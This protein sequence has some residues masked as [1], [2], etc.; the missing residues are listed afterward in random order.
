MAEVA[1]PLMA[2]SGLYIISKNTKNKKKENFKNYTTLKP[3]NLLNDNDPF[4]KPPQNIDSKDTE[5]S[6]YSLN[7]NVINKSDFKHNNMVPFYSGRTNGVM[8]SPDMAEAKLDQMQGSGS[9]IKQKKEQAP[10]FKPQ[11]D[12]NLANGAPNVNDFIQTRINPSMKMANV[13]PWE[14]ER[15]APG[16][17]KGYNGE[18]GIGFNTGMESRE[19]WQPKTVD[20]LRSTTNPKNTYSLCGHQ[21][22]ANAAI[23]EIGNTQTQGRIEKQTPDTYYESGPNR[24]FTT[25]GL[26]K[27]STSRGI[28]LL[29]DTNRQETTEEY[30]GTGGNG[31]HEATYVKSAVALP[32]KPELKT[33]PLSNPIAVGKYSS[34]ENDYCVKSYSNLPNNRSTTK[35]EQQYG[36]AQGIMRAI[37]A[38][39]LD[40][41]RPTRKEN[42]I[43][44]IRKQGNAS[45]SVN[46]GPIYNPNDKTKTTIRQITEDSIGS[47]YQTIGN[48]QQADAYTVSKHQPIS[49]QRDTT[50]S[51]YLGTAGNTLYTANQTYDAG[52]RQRLNENIEHTHVDYKGNAMPGAIAASKTYDA[53]YN[54]RNNENKKHVNYSGNAA[55][56]THGASQTYYSAYNQRNN[57]KKTQ[58]SRNN[59]GG[60][61]IFNQNENISISR[62]DNDRI[63]RRTSVPNVNGRVIPTKELYGKMFS[64]FEK[65]HEDRINP[66]LL[67]AFKNNPYTQSLNSS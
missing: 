34:T 40:I 66:D 60:T 20:Q 12:L 5:D 67:S 33:N 59:Q 24:W 27:A 65:E 54:Q 25:T 45:C 32:R 61:Q 2:L 42:L 48:C 44:N 52:Y 39:V 7:G 53:A 35:H 49:V 43:N 55:P 28:Q 4:F 37:I 17:N 22:P 64:P 19:L 8:M 16:L 23:K 38:P 13:K 3:Q 56:S 15:V 6:H 57:D 26:E 36:G 51:K 30:Y 21:G 18:G 58:E 29:N 62:S 1:V 31:A 11:T 14:E 9:Q 63:N 41:V 10:L 46:K 47:N 50:N